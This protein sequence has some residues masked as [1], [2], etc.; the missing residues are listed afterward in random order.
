MLRLAFERVGSVRNPPQ[1]FASVRNGETTS[2]G[3]KSVCEL[4]RGDV[5]SFR[6]SGA[7]GYGPA[8]ERDPNQVQEDVRQGFVTSEAAAKVYGVTGNSG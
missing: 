8:A 7:G 2:L 5:A 3:S 1:Q 4:Q 6:L